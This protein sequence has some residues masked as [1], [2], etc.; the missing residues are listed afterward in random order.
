MISLTGVMAP[1]PV[2]AVTMGKGS[3]APFAGAWI[4]LG[5]GVVEIPLM[6]L[7]LLGFSAVLK[8]EMVKGIIGLLG[9]LFLL[10]LGIGMFREMRKTDVES[11]ENAHKPLISGMLLS[12]GNPYFLLWWAMVGLKLIERS[13]V[14]GIMGFVLFAL[15]HWLC[16]FIWLL[17]LSFLSFKGK[18]FYGGKFQKGIF[19]LCGL[20]L[21]FFSGMF[22]VDALG[23]LMGS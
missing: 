14:F 21:V 12:I 11:R 6:I 15:C 5:H 23:A 4:A 3:K 20:V 17:I 19:A 16:D 18:T 1:G 9:G 2:T 22:V 10:Y 13:R 8:M 7:L